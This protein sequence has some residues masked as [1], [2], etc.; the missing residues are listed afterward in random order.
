MWWVL[1]GIVAIA[2]GTFVY[3]YVYDRWVQR[4]HAIRRNFP[5]YGRFRYIMENLGEYF[6]QYWFTADWEERPFNRLTRA[7]VYRSAKAVSNYVAFGSEVDA[8]QP[9]HIY[10][11][12]SAFPVNDDEAEPYTGKWIGKG[13][14]ANPFKPNSFFNISG[15]SYGALSSAAVTALSEGAAL[16]GIWLDTGEGGL[17]PYHLKGNCDVV[18][19]IGTAKYG[20]RDKDG[21]LDETKL[22][23]I[24][25][26]PQVKMFCVKLSQGAKPGRGGILPA[27]KVNEEIAGIRLIEP[28]KASISPSRHPE[29]TDV[30]SLVNFIGRVRDVTNKPVGIKMALGDDSFIDALFEY[31]RERPME[32]PDFIQLDGGEGGTGAAPAPL[33]DYVGQSI[34]QALPLLA[35]K[36]RQYG[37]RNR[38]RIIASGKLL[39]PDKVAWAL[40]QGADFVVSARGYMFALGCIQAMKCNTGHCPTGVT[41]N[42]PRFMRGLDP[43]RKAVRV[44]NY[45][46][47]VQHDVEAIAHAC[48]CKSP[49][50]LKAHHVRVQGETLKL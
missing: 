14:V 8:Q 6:R 34:V 41:S 38:I 7:W 48:G 21:R 12:H 36:R 3:F 10:F 25:A 22:A 15:M 33:A 11:L 16:A 18:F 50:D 40:C 1:G 31:L 30:R 42:E 46:K 43:A 47:A 37:L 35:E 2:G 27:A 45:A 23:A 5:I 49:R 13:V 29:I 4:D 9:G 26:L 44:A 24:A 39:T 19:Q 28:H 32:A 20:V 17:S